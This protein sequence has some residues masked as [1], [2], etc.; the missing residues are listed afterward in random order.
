[1]YWIDWEDPESRRTIAYFEWRI[2]GKSRGDFAC[3]SLD[4][5][6]TKRYP[7]YIFSWLSILGHW[8]CNEERSGNARYDLYFHCIRK[9]TNQ[10]NKKIN[11]DR[12]RKC[13]KPLRYASYFLYLKYGGANPDSNEDVAATQYIEKKIQET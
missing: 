3:S 12:K 1:M 4:Y 13:L 2:L 9:A 10:N 8:R 7:L 11:I 5:T 6:F